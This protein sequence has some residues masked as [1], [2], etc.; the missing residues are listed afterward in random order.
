MFLL[1]QKLKPA[2]KAF[3]MKPMRETSSGEESID[4]ANSAM[5]AKFKVN[6]SCNFRTICSDSL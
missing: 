5:K 2:R 6:P 3:D 4:E 1:K